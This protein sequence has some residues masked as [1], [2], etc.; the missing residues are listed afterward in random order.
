MLSTSKSP[1]SKIMS[2]GSEKSKIIPKI[3]D[4]LNLDNRTKYALQNA[5]EKIR[6]LHQV[7]GDLQK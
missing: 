5:Q 7:V 2:P 4:P 6:N 3:H 1:Q